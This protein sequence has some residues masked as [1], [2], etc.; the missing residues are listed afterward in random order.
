MFAQGKYKE[1]AA[2]LYSV[3][4]VG[5]GWDW[6]TM[7]SLYPNVEVYTKQLRALEAAVKQNP[8]ANDARF[9]LAYH[10]LT[11]AARTRRRRSSRSSTRRHRRTT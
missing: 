4:S 11:A 8:Q 10:Y 6:T 1:A 9:V 3:L 5:P 7:C 2:G